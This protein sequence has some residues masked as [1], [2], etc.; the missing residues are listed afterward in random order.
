MT[1]IINFILGGI[2]TIAIAA[3]TFW[4]KNMLTP[5][6]YSRI[7]REEFENIINKYRI[8]KNNQNC[9]SDRALFENSIFAKF[10]WPMPIKAVALI[11]ERE[12]S[13]I[14]LENLHK[15]RLNIKFENNKFESKRSKP[16]SILMSPTKRCID[17]YSY[18]GMTTAVIAALM[19]WCL[20]ITAIFLKEEYQ[21]IQNLFNYLSCFFVITVIIIAKIQSTLIREQSL[22]ELSQ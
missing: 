13:A 15:S 2:G 16:L 7:K 14:N 20:M 6:F 21:N 17:F 18:L 22:I 11:I 9:A 12:K 3:A 1:V 8:Y 4:V 10:G 5:G 19:I